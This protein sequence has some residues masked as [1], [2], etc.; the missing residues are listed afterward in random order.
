[1]IDEVQKR[2]AQLEA[3]SCCLGTVVLV[4]NGATEVTQAA[5]RHSL[6]RGLLTRLGAIGG[7]KLLLTVDAGAGVRARRDLDLLSRSFERHARGNGVQLAVRM[8]DERRVREAFEPSIPLS[9][10]G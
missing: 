5:S 10:A 9:R 1:L 2:A 8:G 4:S 7:G 6:V 3:I